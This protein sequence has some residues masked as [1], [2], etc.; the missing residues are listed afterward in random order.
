MSERDLSKLTPGTLEGIKRLANKIKKRDG[1]QH[2]Q[3]LEVAARQ[4]GFSSFALAQRT[5]VQGKG[6]P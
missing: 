3:A 1:I 4:A 2:A 6:N 5:L